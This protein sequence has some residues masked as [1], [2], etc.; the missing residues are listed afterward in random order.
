MPPMR[1]VLVAAVVL[2]VA[3]V[4]VLAL[5]SEVAQ[6]I[7]VPL[8][9]LPVAVALRKSR[10]PSRG[11]AGH[12]PR[13]TIN[14]AILVATVLAVAIPP[15]LLDLGPGWLIAS[16]AFVIL[17]TVTSEWARRQPA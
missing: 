14:V 13:R 12:A 5:L 9:V 6:L 15:V 8:V 3:S 17:G 4:L 2:V 1:Y 11:P 16:A 7:A 10:P